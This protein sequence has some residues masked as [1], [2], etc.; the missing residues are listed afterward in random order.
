MRG[1]V[2]IYPMKPKNLL[3][4]LLL[5]A[6]ILFAYTVRDILAPFIFAALFAYF[7]DPLVTHME[8]FKLNRAISSLLLI[9]M[10]VF[11]I[12][13]GFF[14]F[15]PELVSQITSLNNYIPS[16]TQFLYDKVVQ[17]LLSFTSEFDQNISDQI[18][19]SFHDIYFISFKYILQYFKKL[20]SSTDSVFNIISFLFVTP[21]ITFYLLRDWPTCVSAMKKSDLTNSNKEVKSLFNDINL[22]LSGYLRGQINVCILMVAFYSI[23]YVIF[24]LNHGLLLGVMTGFLIVIPY[25]GPLLSNLTT[26]IV[27]LFQF[28]SASALIPFLAIMMV[29]QVT[30]GAFITPK[31]VGDKIGLHPVWIF[32][33][34]FSGASLFGFWGVML[35]VPTAAIIRVIWIFYCKH[36]LP[37]N[38]VRSE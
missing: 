23:S 5:T 27:A 25:L 14:V 26:L 17:K 34:I 21:I 13:F 22:A 24:E 28:G 16:I 38:D 10:M 37:R 30:E 33:A 36:Y 9:L 7:L 6:L 29:G 11:W 12:G 32:F 20:L 8:R 3:I 35:A 4:A 18:K 15:I 2:T 31:L 19:D 1:K